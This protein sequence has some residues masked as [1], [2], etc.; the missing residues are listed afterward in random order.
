MATPEVAQKLLGSVPFML[1][2]Q[3][4]N[5]PQLA[6]EF[7]SNELPGLASR[8]AEAL[9]QAQGFTEDLW[10]SFTSHTAGADGIFQALYNTMGEFSGLARVTAGAV[11]GPGGVPADVGN[12]LPLERVSGLMGALMSAAG[13]QPAEVARPDGELETVYPLVAWVKTQA[14]AGGLVA[15]FEACHDTL[16]GLEMGPEAVLRTEIFPRDPGYASC[17]A[18]WDE[19]WQSEWGPMDTSDTSCSEA[20]P[21]G[22]FP[23]EEA[24]GSCKCT[25]TSKFPVAL[26]FWLGGTYGQADDVSAALSDAASF[27]LTAASALVEVTSDSN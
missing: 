19:R 23:G 9:E 13:L 22:I 21:E 7:L 14:Q 24:A 26:S 3:D 8:T 25:L 4:V 10:E 6:A 5:W 12:E 16:R 27:C 20:A 15:V 17:K 2:D 11:S 18:Q 1:G